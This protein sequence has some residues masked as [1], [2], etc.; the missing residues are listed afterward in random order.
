MSGNGYLQLA[1]YL[2]VLLALAKPLGAYMARIYDGQP[3]LLSRIGGPFER[4]I[5]RACGV[6]AS[7]EMD[8]VGYTVALL[9][10]N[11][12]GGLAVYGLQRL[13]A[14]LPLNP[15]GMSAVSPDSSFNTAISFMTN[16]NWQGY[17]GES[18]MSY[19]T[20]M[21]GLGVQNFVSAATGI[22]VV[23]ALTRAFARQSAYDDRQFL[24][25]PDA[26]DALHP[27]AAVVRPRAR[28][29]FTGRRADVLGVSDR[30]RSSN[31]S[32]TTRRN[33]TPPVSR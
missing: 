19:L 10:F 3:S 25:R 6:D 22:V 29:R 26:H 16:T 13:Q 18:T 4:V 14:S 30:H 8:W 28:A 5:Y 31:R 11:L 24:G 21:A 17:G 23:I 2:V 20:Q 1:F 12:V 27:A 32:S 15:A 7:K 33:S 9:M